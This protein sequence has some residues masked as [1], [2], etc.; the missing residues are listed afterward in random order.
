MVV[1]YSSIGARGND[2]G[3]LTTYTDDLTNVHNI[4]GRDGSSDVGKEK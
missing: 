3:D 1:I 2:Y 4:V